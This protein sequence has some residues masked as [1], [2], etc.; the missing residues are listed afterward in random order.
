MIF[1]IV[2]LFLML[3]L[4]SFIIP[5]MS[6]DTPTWKRLF[7]TFSEKIINYYCTT[8]EG[9]IILKFMRY[10]NFAYITATIGY[11]LISLTWNHE[12]LDI[13]F[14]WKEIDQISFWSY[15]CIN[16]FVVCVY[17][18][19]QRYGGAEA[20][21][22]H[23]IQSEQHSEIIRLQE[24][25]HNDVLGIKQIIS[26]F[27][28][29]SRALLLSHIKDVK[30]DIEKLRLTSAYEH[31]ES[32]R[33][34]HE[35][36]CPEDK[37]TLAL[38]EYWEGCC[39]K[40]SNTN[41]AVSHFKEAHNYDKNGIIT[42][43]SEEYI[44]A[45]CYEGKFES[46][47]E[48]INNNA[49][50]LKDSIWIYIPEF[51][52]CENKV[53]YFIHK[54]I[55]DHK[56]IEN[57]LA[58]TLIL[59]QK[60]D[61]ELDLSSF[62]IAKDDSLPLTYRSF[63][64][65]VLKLSAGLSSF[66]KNCFW[67]FNGTNL[68]TPES[69]SLFKL[70]STFKKSSA[71]KEV[72]LVMPDLELYYAATGYL[73]DR[74]SHWIEIIQTQISTCHHKDFAYLV[75]SFALFNSGKVQEGI[76]TLR[77]YSN[78]SKELTWNLI[79]MLV[80]VGNWLEIQAQMKLL[81]DKSDNLVPN[82][83]CY[84]L[85]NLV[86]C[87][88]DKFAE[89]AKEFQLDNQISTNILHGLIDFFAGEKQS[90]AIYLIEHEE[91]AIAQL[92][93]FYPYVYRELGNLDKAIT[94]VQ[95]YITP[96]VIDAATLLYV[97]LMEEDKR[98]L[99][100]IKFLR[101]LR[102]SGA[103]HIP[104]LFTELR[105]SFLTHNHE[106]SIAICE[107]LTNEFPDS[108]NI[109]YNKI[110]SYY[111]A[112]KNI[113]DFETAYNV[114]TNGILNPDHVQNLFYILLS[115]GK[116]IEALDF[117]YDQVNIAKDQSLRDFYYNI[118]L[119]SEVS[120]IISAP[121]DT[122]EIGD[123]ITYTDGT[124]QYSTTL[125]KDEFLSSFEGKSVGEKLTLDN[126]VKKITFT[127]QG[128]ETKYAGLLHEI[129]PSILNNRS[130][131]IRVF[132]FEDIKD[133]PIQ[134]IKRIVSAYSGRDDD[135]YTKRI[136]EQISLYKNSKCPLFLVKPINDI[137]ELYNIIFGDFKIYQVPFQQL[138]SRFDG[139]IHF[140]QMNIV[141]DLS[142]I[143]LIHAIARKFGLKYAQKFLIGQRIYD[144]IKENLER[145]KRGF[146]IGIYS[147]SVRNNLGHLVKRENEQAIKLENFLED[148]LLWISENCQ[149]Q[150]V[151]EIVNYEE[152]ES[153]PIIE[154]HFESILLALRP[155]S[156]LISEDIWLCNLNGAPA[157][158]NV[159]FLTKSIHPEYSDMVSRYLTD[160]N[161]VGQT[162]DGKY[163][164]EQII[165][166]ERGVNEGYE[167][168]IE[169]IKHNPYVISSYI[170]A[171][172]SFIQG[173]VTSFRLQ[174]ISEIYFII[175]ETLGYRL[176]KHV[177]LQIQTF[178]LPKELT[179]LIDI[180]FQKLESQQVI[181]AP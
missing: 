144:Y 26:R 95:S 133:D 69:E 32:I 146:P 162:I 168:C 35:L 5:K 34:Q 167:R 150:I 2:I 71:S 4:V 84:I 117:L 115:L 74:K 181:L 106:E 7:V 79:S 164:I 175:F 22:D 40:Y 149:V 177:Y 100:L 73:R 44:F 124:R 6:K 138:K 80:S 21:K 23:K 55:S 56:T 170:S 178:H 25:T 96:N 9:R 139:Y 31:L 134:G 14:E 157:K 147:L 120:D 108:A 36:H 18:I 105:L 24:D 61:M 176:A 145:E 82:I 91:D 57:I 8:S 174:A 66:L 20:K 165:A 89:L 83:G 123:Y 13:I 54:Q 48:Y 156:I 72:I 163:I 152:K 128:V 43:I 1:S 10:T 51:L 155:K 53:E 140:E 19:N 77:N 180:A 49:S 46:A 86:R 109:A 132:S 136:Q 107:I 28:D 99:E 125:L 92:K 114:I 122:A 11:P 131:T 30:N 62:S 121:K 76:D 87:F 33:N 63:P 173:I 112:G 110:V 98:N 111:K 12:G 41:K 37:Y 101:G 153:D 17:L 154:T 88:P 148:L 16:A 52:Q 159:E 85:I 68:S 179:R 137:G 126:G 102:I 129:T 59:L 27:P 169:L 93:P 90:S 47:F 119:S 141:L 29:S 172:V 166:K 39:L 171:S 113:P 127:L 50:F 81:L 142:S 58:Q 103:I 160:L 45:L 151:E 75:L 64:I 67:R 60:H 104:F 130:K 70:I 94:L 118:H 97:E 3:Y 65:W 158:I 15:L 116:K 42:E 78:R 135:D 143:I 38:I 161:Y